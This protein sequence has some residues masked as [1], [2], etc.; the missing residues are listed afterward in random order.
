MH[1]DYYSP[2]LVVIAMVVSFRFTLAFSK[3]EQLVVLRHTTSGQLGG[4]AL[5]NA[6][7][8]VL[9]SKRNLRSFKR[10]LQGRSPSIPTFSVT[11]LNAMRKMDVF[12]VYV[13]QGPEVQFT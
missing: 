9:L 13:S 12:F 11:R 7:Q 3:A 1:V 4:A 6:I 5:G 2:V 10:P 8:E